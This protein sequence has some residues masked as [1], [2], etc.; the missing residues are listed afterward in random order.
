M[1]RIHSITPE[2]IDDRRF[3]LPRLIYSGD[4]LEP[5]DFHQVTAG[6]EW[7]VAYVYFVFDTCGEL[8]YVGRTASPL[9]RWQ[10]HR[11]KAR[12]WPHATALNLYRVDGADRLSSDLGV[13]HWELHAIHGALPRYNLQGPAALPAKAVET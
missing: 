13:R 4:M 8:L 5:H 10:A 12:W 7:S 2:Y 6:A 11:R 1:A 9:N 3:T